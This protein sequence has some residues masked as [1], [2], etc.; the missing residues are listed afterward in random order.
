L[1]GEEEEGIRKRRE[2]GHRD[3]FDDERCMHLPCILG[4]PISETGFTVQ[5]KVNQSNVMGLGLSLLVSLNLF[6][7]LLII[8]LFLT[9]I[10]TTI[11]AVII[12]IS[13]CTFYFNL[14]NNLI[15]TIIIIIIIV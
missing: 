10:I 3:V 14:Y 7:F 9:P 11:N 6:Y 1:K 15:I 8:Y 2:E 4:K 12:F 13:W 5:E